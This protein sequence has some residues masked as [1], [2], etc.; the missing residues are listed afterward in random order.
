M[1]FLRTS[2]LLL[3]LPAFALAAEPL[4]SNDFE[5]SE[6]GVV[7]KDFL[8]IGGSF[9]VQ[10]DGANKVLELPGA[11]LDMFGAMFGPSVEAGVC[12]SGKFFGTSV[13]RK[14]PAF[15]ISANGYRLQVSA[16]KK[17]VEIFKGDESRV[18]VPFEWKSGTW[19]SLRIQ[20]RKA[21]SG[22]WMI[23]GRAWP[24]GSPE[25]KDW[26]ISLEEKDAPAAGRP[27]IWGSPFSGTPIR[28]DDLL[29]EPAH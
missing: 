18:S 21:A 15:G 2:A 22:L 26:T 13:G 14:F 25:P 29:V 27:G 5:K 7:P 12:A 10:A 20:L 1:T 24:A 6:V 9:T 8:V 28:F 17:A 23:E 16:G 11:P 4:Y 3:A 19:T